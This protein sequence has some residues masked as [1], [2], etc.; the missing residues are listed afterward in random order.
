MKKL[1]RI[2]NL[3]KKTEGINTVGKLSKKKKKINL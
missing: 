1:L 2:Y 3:K